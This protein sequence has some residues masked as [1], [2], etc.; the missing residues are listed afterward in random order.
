MK[1]TWGMGKRPLVVQRSTLGGR[2]ETPNLDVRRLSTPTIQHN[3][4]VTG[5]YDLRLETIAKLIEE[6]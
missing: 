6:L 2:D 3:G 5:G 1:R 4:N